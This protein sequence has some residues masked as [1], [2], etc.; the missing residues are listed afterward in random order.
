MEL[1]SEFVLGQELLDMGW[2]RP[3]IAKRAHQGARAYCSSTLKFLID[4]KEYIKFLKQE[5]AFTEK[6]FRD[7]YNR[8][9]D[10]M[11]KM[12]KMKEKINEIREEMY[13]EKNILKLDLYRENS[14]E[15]YNYIEGLLNKK[16]KQLKKIGTSFEIWIHDEP[17][18][19]PYGDGYFGPQMFGSHAS[20]IRFANFEHPDFDFSQVL[21]L[22]SDIPELNQD[23][24]AGGGDQQLEELNGGA[25][26]LVSPEPEAVA[27]GG[28]ASKSKEAHHNAEEL[29]TL[30]HVK[31]EKPYTKTP[32]QVLGELKPND[33]A[34]RLWLQCAELADNGKNYKTIGE[35]VKN[36]QGELL[37]KKQAGRYVRSGRRLLQ[38]ERKE[39]INK[40]MK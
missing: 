28:S 16:I 13:Y 36:T 27:V 37:G 33:K 15:R 40:N 18:Y 34:G 35:T 10:A 30:E 3:D 9:Y 19:D 38:G 8:M 12:Q 24:E 29:A 31:Q 39:E 11:E 2:K 4:V 23:A 17:I 26:K 5:G 32:A 22:R 14:E 20:Q 21:F 6:D 7:F 1:K 25:G